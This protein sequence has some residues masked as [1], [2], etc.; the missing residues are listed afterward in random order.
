MKKSV[1]AAVMLLIVAV[2]AFGKTHNETYQVSCSELWNAVQD[3]I[4]HSG[5]YTLVVADNAKMTASYH[6]SGTLHAR[7]NSVHLQPK[8]TGCEMQ[9]QSSF[10]G[11]MQNDAGDFKT[12]VDRSLAKLKASQPSESAKPP[13]AGK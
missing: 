9:I 5:S 11:V 2:P 1:V 8:G 12:R 3:T 4:N 10:S 13:D 7:D 6:I